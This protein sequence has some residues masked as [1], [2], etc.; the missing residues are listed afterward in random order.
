MATLDHVTDLFQERI[1]D[2]S[3]DQMEKAGDLWPDLPLNFFYLSHADDTVDIVVRSI[4]KRVA[5][6]DGVTL[7]GS[8]L[9]NLVILVNPDTLVKK[10]IRLVFLTT[11]SPS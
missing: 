11:F 1:T 10:A 8:V 5:K 3:P 9:D 4:A 7:P 6:E 2:D